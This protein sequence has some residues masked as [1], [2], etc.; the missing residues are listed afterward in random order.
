MPCFPFTELNGE[1]A[2]YQMAVLTLEKHTRTVPVSSLPSTQALVACSQDMD[3]N[4]AG[5]MWL[6]RF[7]SWPQKS[8]GV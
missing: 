3:S 2:P 8:T 6:F 7:L 5:P 1:K 4:Q